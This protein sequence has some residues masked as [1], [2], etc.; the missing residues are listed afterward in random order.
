MKVDDSSR[1][2]G[3]DRVTVLCMDLLVPGLG[4]LIGGSE[5]EDRYEALQRRMEEAKLPLEQYQW[6]LDL[7][8][9]GSVQHSGFGLGFERY[10]R[11]V[12]GVVNLR[13]LIPVPRGPGS[14]KF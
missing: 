8:K 12:T 5:R 2:E 1:A 14:L 13:D 4:E 10:L 6:Y 9:Y 3:V 7:R 11:L